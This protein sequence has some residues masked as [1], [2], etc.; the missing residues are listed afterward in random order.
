MATE[1]I[2]ATEWRDCLKAHYRY[3]VQN[4]DEVTLK[5]LIPVL[6]DVGF[7]EDDLRAIYVEVTMHVDDVGPDFMPN[8]ARAIE[9]EAKAPEPII[10][11]EPPP[12]PAVEGQMGDDESN[13]DEQD[14][15]I[16]P[17]PQQMS[18]F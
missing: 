15:Y 18:L 6:H 12:M 8:L 5:T 14:R 4:H 13:E 17:P 2:F 7:T 1:N 11:P 3:T 9:P 10:E 16:P